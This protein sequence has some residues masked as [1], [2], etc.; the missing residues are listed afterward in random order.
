M[1]IHSLNRL[2][3]DGYYL[4]SDYLNWTF[5]ER[6]ELIMGKIFRMSPGASA[7]HQDCS[8]KITNILSGQ[9]NQKHCKLFYAPF[10]LVLKGSS[11]KEDCVVQPDL[12]ICCDRSKITEKACI[13]APELVI[14]IVSTFSLKRD[15]VEKHRLYELNAVKEYWVV[16]PEIKSINRYQLGSNQ[17]FL[18]AEPFSFSEI[19]KSSSL[20]GIV[21]NL[22]EIFSDQ[23]HESPVPYGLNIDSLT[24]I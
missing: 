3:P 2:D 9:L 7:R 15:T 13:G 10:D 20:Q 22:E 5:P 24:R 16:F 14:E 21:L 6:V 23:V 1:K 11:G 4:Y 18:D 8:R 19:L 17:K 12:L